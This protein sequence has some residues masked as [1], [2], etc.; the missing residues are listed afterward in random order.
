MHTVS[1]S[2]VPARWASRAVGLVIVALVALVGLSACASQD[3]VE[4][5]S[6]AVIVDVRTPSEFAEGHLE[7]A[8]NLDVSSATFAEDVAALPQDGEYV[9]YCRS[10]NRSGQATRL[11][12]DLGYPNV[13]DAGS[14]ANASKLTGLAVVT[15]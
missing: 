12:T 2:S 4:I 5:G 6:D 7:G 3:P 15:D 14:V 9:L 8:L 10:G 11:M 13:V 1:L